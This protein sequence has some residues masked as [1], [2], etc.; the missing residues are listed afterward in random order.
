MPVF[1]MFYALLEL[2]Y[3]CT[4]GVLCLYERYER[5]SMPV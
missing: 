1:H 5:C 3:A 2:F 4:R